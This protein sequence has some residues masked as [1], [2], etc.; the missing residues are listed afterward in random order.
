[1]RWTVHGERPVYESDWVNVALADVEI[2]GG[3]RFEHHVV[4]APMKAAGV[5]VLDPARGVLLLWRHRFITDSW[6]WEIPAGR[7]ERGELAADAAAREVLEET[8]WRPGRLEPLVTYHP[9]NGISD[10]VFHIYTSAGAEYVGEPVDV[11]ESERIEW[12]TP[13][14]LRAAIRD[15]DMPDGLSLTAVLYAFAFGPLADDR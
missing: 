12:L 11:S 13:D 5:V 3:E 14:E 10:Q 15:G 7:I 8:G 2:P 4:R 9:S 6:G 1:M